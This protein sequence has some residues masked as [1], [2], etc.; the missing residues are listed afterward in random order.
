MEVITKSKMLDM[1]ARCEM[2]LAERRFEEGSM[3]T[4]KLLFADSSRKYAYIASTREKNADSMR[5]LE[6]ALKLAVRGESPKEIYRITSRIVE[7]EM[8]PERRLVMA[9]L[10]GDGVELPGTTFIRGIPKITEIHSTEMSYYK[11][12]IDMRN[13]N[14]ERLLAAA[15]DSDMKRVLLNLTREQAKVVD[16]SLENAEVTLNYAVPLEFIDISSKHRRENS[17]Y[18]KN[19]IN[20]LSGGFELLLK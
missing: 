14:F 5:T 16:G 3:E 1:L 12:I 20:V 15:E 10:R 4:A 19:M 6:H 18:I 9:E 17:D 8:F 11:Y 13:G 2:G 7:L